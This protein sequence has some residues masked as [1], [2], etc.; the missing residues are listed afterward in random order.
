MYLLSKKIQHEIQG[1]HMASNSRGCF[2]ITCVSLTKAPVSDFHVLVFHACKE[3]NRDF[4]VAVS[5]GHFGHVSAILVAIWVT[6]EG[7]SN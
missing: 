2:L 4:F 5:A 6:A 3:P 7:H 1:T